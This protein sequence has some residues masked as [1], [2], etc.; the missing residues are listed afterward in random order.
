M[1]KSWEG[2][3]VL[4][5]W[6]SLSEPVTVSLETAEAQRHEVTWESTQHESE[7]RG[8]PCSSDSP[9]NFLCPILQEFTE[10]WES[11]Y[12]LGF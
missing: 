12:G 1:C 8:K 3:C 10:Y 2:T 4:G 7:L 6:S 5:F 9:F 11:R